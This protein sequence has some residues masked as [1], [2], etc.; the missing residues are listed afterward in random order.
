MIEV[1]Y[2]PLTH[3]KIKETYLDDEGRPHRE[4]GPAMRTFTPT[5]LEL[6]S[7]YFQHGVITRDDGPAIEELD[8]ENQYHK[9][10][11]LRDGLKDRDDGPAEI[12][13]DLISGVEFSVCFY[14]HNK[15]HRS[16][17]PALITRDRDTGDVNAKFVV[18]NG[19]QQP[20]G[21]SADFTPD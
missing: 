15:M 12:C 17:G 19:Q 10:V 2:H 5:G 8:L 9:L 20:N 3:K 16:Q 6:S 1:E 21:S 11:W 13:T 7:T 4:D 14:R 18:I